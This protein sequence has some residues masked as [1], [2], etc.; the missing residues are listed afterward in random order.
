MKRRLTWLLLLSGVLFAPG[1]VENVWLP[2]SSGFVFI[3][4]DHCLVHFD[5]ATKT[6]RVIARH[7]WLC[8]DVD[9][10][11]GDR[12]AVSPD[13]KQV[14]VV[15]HMSSSRLETVQILAYDLS[16]KAA[17]VSPEIALPGHADLSPT[18]VTK[19]GLAFW[20]PDG[21][22]I[23]FYVEARLARGRQRVRL[24][25]PL[26]ISTLGVYELSTRRHTLFTGLELREEE[27]ATWGFS[28]FTPDGRGFLAHRKRKDRPKPGE[29][30]LVAP[31]PVWHSMTFVDWQGRE[32][33]FKISPT[34][35]EAWAQEA[36]KERGRK[37][38]GQFAH[39]AVIPPH[40]EKGIA[41]FPADRGQYLVDPVNLVITFGPN[42]T[43]RQLYDYAV[44]E[45]V[46]VLLLK[47]DVLIQGRG[48]PSENGPRKPLADDSGTPGQRMEI[49]VVIG[50]QKG[51]MGK[52][53]I[54]K[55]ATVDD[56][57]GCAAAPN[58]QYVLVSCVEDCPGGERYRRLV[59]DAKGKI[60]ADLPEKTVIKRRPPP[61][62]V[63]PPPVKAV[64][65]QP[66]ADQDP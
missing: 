6:E 40:W 34:V 52:G 47:D 26:G 19:S 30:Q 41:V 63:A 32:Q 9:E 35:Q 3:R 12:P 39:D 23:L 64:D 61:G 8:T 24:S 46:D 17:H 58:G 31:T 66:P 2:D 16:G 10:L 54:I 53:K 29:T 22:R 28:P 14:A 56:V 45:D 48:V 50:V 59:L 18:P 43:C 62:P 25:D 60:I 1:C 38:S 55:V 7:D 37:R 15:R 49:E 51:N 5:L 33:R 42:E 4:S 11:P 13:G 36:A 20:S 57:D 27:V 21:Q 65:P 44:R